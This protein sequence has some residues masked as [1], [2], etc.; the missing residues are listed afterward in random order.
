MP[1]SRELGGRRAAASWTRTAA[2]MRAD[3][4]SYNAAVNPRHLWGYVERYA[5]YRLRI[6]RY[7]ISVAPS[8]RPARPGIWASWARWARPASSGSAAPP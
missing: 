2:R 3:V 7:V 5:V 6:F 1:F 8:P 4:G